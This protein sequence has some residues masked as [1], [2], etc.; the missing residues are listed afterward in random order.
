MLCAI[1]M[2]RGEGGDLFES[3]NCSLDPKQESVSITGVPYTVHPR[4]IRLQADTAAD[5]P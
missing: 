2:N 1:A 4:S 5:K 3:F